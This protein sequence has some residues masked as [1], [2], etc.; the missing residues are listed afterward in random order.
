MAHAQIGDVLAA[1]NARVQDLHPGAHFLQ[2][3]DQPDSQR[4]HHH[5]FDHHVGAGDDER[6]HQSERAGR[7][8]SGH[9]HVARLQLGTALERD[10]PTVRTIGNAA[11]SGAEI[12]QHFLGVVTRGFR[13]NHNCSARRVQPRQ[14]DC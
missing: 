6:G 14:Q 1:L 13:F 8:V 4:V 9:D 10:S 12:G 5:A 3:R 7:R 2:R 11:D